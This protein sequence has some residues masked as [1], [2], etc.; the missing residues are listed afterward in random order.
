MSNA[1]ATEGTSP[2]DHDWA[3]GSLPCTVSGIKGGPR[4]L[5]LSKIIDSGG[6]SQA[7]LSVL[8][9]VE[10]LA[11]LTS[12]FQAMTQAMEAG[13]A[14]VGTASFRKTAG[15]RAIAAWGLEGLRGSLHSR[16]AKVFSPALSEQ[17]IATQQPP[18]TNQ[19][20]VV[21]P[22]DQQE[23]AEPPDK[24]KEAAA[25]SVSPAPAGRDKDSVIAQLRARLAGA[26]ASCE[27]VKT[28]PGTSPGARAEATAAAAVAP[29]TVA[30]VPTAAQGSAA[31]N[32]L[33]QEE[34]RKLVE[35]VQTTDVPSEIKHRA[36]VDPTRGQSATPAMTC[37]QDHASHGVRLTP[38]ITSADNSGVDAVLETMRDASGVVT[39]HN[40]RDRLVEA[41][42]RAS[43]L[44]LFGERK[45]LGDVIAR[46]TQME[47]VIRN[48][49]GIQGVL[50]QMLPSIRGVSQRAAEA[51]M[52]KM[53]KLQLTH[54]NQFSVLGAAGYGGAASTGV[55]YRGG[56]PAVRSY[57]EVV[58]AG[59]GARAS[60]RK[61]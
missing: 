29:T 44:N 53:R 12:S 23:V 8:E 28:I 45:V 20:Q 39:W 7:Q 13:E 18:S 37:E 50:S 10:I 35:L 16:G 17:S 55:A 59:G 56:F 38:T 58:L 25:A 14:T 3:I 4:V 34:N 21:T 27:V 5:D 36:R 11:S 19:E 57:G 61:H 42:Q 26:E 30:A 2:L 46:G 1:A 47:S 33:R 48:P 52:A 43:N 24:Q 41:M 54:R 49:A 22:T 6:S 40:L 32:V 31:N 60:G 51:D 15:L 9:C